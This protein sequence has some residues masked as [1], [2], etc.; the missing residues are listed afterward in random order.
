[1]VE[2]DHRIHSDQLAAM[3]LKALYWLSL[4]DVLSAAHLGVV[5]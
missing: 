3:V 1:V 4:A 2:A 5:T